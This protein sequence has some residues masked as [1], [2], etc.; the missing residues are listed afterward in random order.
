M[1]KSTKFWIFATVC[2]VIFTIIYAITNGLFSFVTILNLI[3]L[4]LC[5]IN[6]IMV[7]KNNKINLNKNVNK[8]INNIKT[9]KMNK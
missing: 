3:I 7:S 1:Y 8:N 6:L 4:I 2:F 9:N 5:I